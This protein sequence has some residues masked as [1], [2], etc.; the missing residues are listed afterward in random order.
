MLT[1]EQVLRN[2]LQDV[3]GNNFKYGGLE[4]VI[5]STILPQ[6][7][8]EDNTVHECKRC[9]ETR[10]LKCKRVNAMLDYKTERLP[11]TARLAVFRIQNG[12]L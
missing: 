11:T 6:N 8:L 12:V 3:L 1:S 10:K 9:L 4:N 2:E 5:S 7:V